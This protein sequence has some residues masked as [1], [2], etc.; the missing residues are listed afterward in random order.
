M[1]TLGPEMPLP[2]L[3]SRA[4]IRT[5]FGIKLRMQQFLPLAYHNPD[6]HVQ[7][8]TLTGSRIGICGAIS[9]NVHQHGKT[10]RPADR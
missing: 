9:C 10:L 1:T 5:S 6:V 7:D 2:A 8:E 3:T 4:G